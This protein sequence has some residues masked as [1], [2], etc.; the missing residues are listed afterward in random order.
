MKLRTCVSPNGRFV[1]GIHRPQF[2]VDNFRQTDHLFDLGAFADGSRLR[3][4][5][6][7]PKGRVH[8]P[9]A[10]RIYE[11]PNPFPFRGTTYIGKAWADDRAR[12][13]ASI[14]L[15]ASPAVS[16]FKD[17]ADEQAA[18]DAIGNLP[19]TLKLALA[20]SSTDTRDLV[21]LAHLACEF[22]MDHE[23]KL[24]WGMAYERSSGGKIRPC[25][26]DEALFDAVA[27]NRH[28]PD[29]YKQTMVLRPGAQGKSEIVGEWQGP[30]SHVF[31]YLR[32]N[33]YIP[34]G[35]YA[36]NMANDAERYRL[37]DLTWQDMTGMRHLYYQ[38]SYTRMAM[39]T[40]C[41]YTGAEGTLS[42]D[43]L[44]K[45]RQAV[46][47]SLATNGRIDFNRTLWGWNFGYDYAP[48]GYRLHASHQ[49]IHQQFALI[50]AMIPLAMDQTRSLPAYACGDLIGDFIDDFR[51][52]TGQ[53]FFDCYHRAITENQRMDERSDRDHRL[54]VF[55]DEQVMLFV[56]K[57]QTSQWELQLMPKNAVGNIL[58]ADSH[59]RRSL[60]RAILVAVKVLG[61]M[62]ARMITSIEYS[63]PVTNKDLDQRL[64]MSFMPRLPE[65]PGAFS[66]AQL[67]WIN[68]HYPEDFALACRS[69]LPVDQ[70]WMVMP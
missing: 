18:F 57:A 33:S 59:M 46:L 15:P 37:S 12:S 4:E 60:D 61:S 3:N 42:A 35:H 40:G 54:V 43:A 26:V 64:L 19:R 53:S 9:A 20:V 49:Q 39:D 27:N 13:P 70:D 69:H 47:D 7:F 30:Q 45:L 25:I 68:G 34:W 36:A 14:R 10:D 16:F 22:C 52:K 6:N 56:P 1:F 51:R 58:E 28:L 66:E 50:P 23:K 8:E 29:A 44:E 62:G 11:V 48:N 5:I 67:R 38:R 55:E 31:E 21:C 41:P 2:T 32:R 65:S 24:P 17:Y 63:K